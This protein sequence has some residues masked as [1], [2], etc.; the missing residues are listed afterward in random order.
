MF[1]VKEGLIHAEFN[2][3][4]LKRDEGGVVFCSDETSFQVRGVKGDI[5][6][7]LVSLNVDKRLFVL[8]LNHVVL[9]VGLVEPND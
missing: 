7:D 6:S 4:R 9:L 2:L 3:A 5:A 1:A 8:G